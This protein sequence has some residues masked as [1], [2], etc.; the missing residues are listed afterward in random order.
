MRSSGIYATSR[1]AD[2][3][4]ISYRG[5]GSSRVD[6]FLVVPHSAGRHPAVL[7][8]HGSGG[9]RQDL[10]GP[11]AKLAL[12][13]AVTMTITEPSDAQTYRPLVVDAR[14]ALDVLAARR[15]VDASRLGVVGFSL[16]GQIAAIL[17]GAD[18]RPKAVGI[19]AGRGTGVALLLDPAG[20]RPPLLPGRDRRT[21]RPARAA[22]RA[23][24]RGSRPPPHPLVC[25][26]PRAHGPAPA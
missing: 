10:I 4:T 2:V 5:A 23:H 1:K 16:G 13:G 3:H 18:P 26:R 14:R 17:A 21:G 19:V 20:A 6:A 8:L 11:A 7:F 12:G 15:D 22:A 24:A 25:D 9:S